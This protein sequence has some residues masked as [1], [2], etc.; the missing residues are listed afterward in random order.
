M[1]TKRSLPHSQQPTI[2]HYPEQHQSSPCP[3]THFLK[4]HFNI[5]LQSKPTSSKWSLSLRSPHQNS[6]CNFHVSHTCLMPRP[7]HSS[8]FISPIIFCEDYRSWSSSSF[9]FLHFPV[10]SSFLGPTPYPR[11]HSAYISPSS[12]QA[13]GMFRN[14]LNFYGED[15]LAPRPTRDLEDLQLPAVRDCLL[16]IFAATLHLEVV[17]PSA[18]WRRAIPRW[19]RSTYHG[20]GQKKWVTM[21]TRCLTLSCRTTYIYIY[22]Y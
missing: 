5:T 1:E 7:F 18:T 8:G 3:Q 12:W 9:C 14:V 22:I 2:C 16:N 10:T 13:C 4:I 6:V 17:P 19:E 21:P 15:L 20:D 11:T